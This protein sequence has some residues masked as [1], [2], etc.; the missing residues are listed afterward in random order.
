MNCTIC[1]SRNIVTGYT[2]TILT[3]H[4]RV[5]K[6]YCQEHLTTYART[7]EKSNHTGKLRDTNIDKY[8]EVKNNINFIPLAYRMK[9]NRFG[10][11]VTSHEETTNAS[12]QTTH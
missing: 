12:L 8:N 10:E 9:V 3:K 11:V 2:E 4:K 6:V 1:K 5:T 7:M